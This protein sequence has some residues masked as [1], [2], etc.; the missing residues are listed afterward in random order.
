MVFC[1]AENICY[2]CSFACTGSERMA[3][4]KID[5][6]ETTVATG[7]GA[8][9]QD[10]GCKLIKVTSCLIKLKIEKSHFFNANV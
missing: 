10:T 1:F 9:R 2:E 4:S 3:G 8:A 5:W 6:T 7:G